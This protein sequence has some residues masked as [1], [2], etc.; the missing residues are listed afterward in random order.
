MVT[1]V[2]A[3]GLLGVMF[4]VTW[5]LNKEF[6]E[7]GMLDQSIIS[8]SVFLYRY[9]DPLHMKIGKDQLIPAILRL[10]DDG[11]KFDTVQTFIDQQILKNADTGGREGLFKKLQGKHLTPLQASM[12]MLGCYGKFN[13]TKMYVLLQLSESQSENIWTNY[14]TAFLLQALQDSAS[15]APTRNHDRSAC[16]CM[17]DFASPTTL[18][19]EDDKN[20][21]GQKLE[22]MQIGKELKDTCQLQNTIDYA[23]DGSGVA[24]ATADPAPVRKS[25][26]LTPLA[27]TDEFKRQR[28]DPL[29]KTLTDERSKTTRIPSSIIGADLKAFV[30]EYC[31]INT[32]CPDTWGKPVTDTTINLITNQVF[33]DA[34]V[35][36]TKYVEPYNKMLPP[37]LCGNGDGLSKVCAENLTHH[38]RAEL[39][40]AGYHAYVDKY[41]KALQLCAASG[42]P[43]YTIWHEG[44]MLTNRVYTMGQVFLLFAAVWAFAW[45]YTVAHI[46][47]KNKELCVDETSKSTIG[48][49]Y[50]DQTSKL[51]IDESQKQFG[52]LVKS[53]HQLYKIAS[54]VFL[55]MCVFVGVWLCLSAY[56]NAAKEFPGLSPAHEPEDDQ[57]LETQLQNDTDRTLEFFRLFW[58]LVIAT[59][60]AGSLFFLLE[61]YKETQFEASKKETEKLKKDVELLLRKADTEVREHLLAEEERKH[62]NERAEEERR[63]KAQPDHWHDMHPL[64]KQFGV[65]STYHVGFGAQP[66]MTTNSIPY[67]DVLQI[68]KKQQHQY[69]PFTQNTTHQIIEEF[70]VRIWRLEKL[71]PYVQVMFDLAVLCGLANLAV[72]CVAQQGVG[73]MTL[74]ST[75]FLWF[76][77]I[78]LLV[79]LS[80]MLRLMHVYLQFDSKLHAHDDVQAVARH[81]AWLI[82]V[83][84]VMLL[85]YLVLGG[86]Q[87]A[88][89]KTSHTG[90]HKLWVCFCTLLIVCGVDFFEHMERR[91]P[92][93]QN[94]RAQAE[95]YWNHVSKKSYYLGWIILLSLFVLQFNRGQIL[96]AASKNANSY[97]TN[98]FFRTR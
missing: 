18:R 83:L 70:N 63:G 97:T 89:V 81:R 90:T 67:A 56:H 40:L 38:P 12:M 52:D 9:R 7:K 64:E 46:I 66:V 14:T 41:A 75:V 24:I 49:K 62:L 91:Q 25:L 73:D 8:D 69:Y 59:L 27:L 36:R 35:G 93:D 19:L 77:A 80:N 71:A 42:V 22:D 95:R 74:L 10:A 47:A 43:K 29:N 23:L 26:M 3:I 96:C 55:V 79:H 86:T 76:T 16:T 39:S 60:C 88:T 54:V 28:P 5:P 11:S 17:K 57:Y 37:K 44:T 94:D 50:I 61:W 31:K 53:E 33:F 34:L 21:D 58:Y 4:Y 84:V 1:V 82:L 68:T 2:L 15:S 6:E 87:T 20:G 72:A 85:I 51:T 98:C 48:N 45:C 65:S 30:R 78:G 13:S 92:V 32:T